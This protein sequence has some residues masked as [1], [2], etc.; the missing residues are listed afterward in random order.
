MK[1]R[2]EGR[3]EGKRQRQTSM[4]TQTLRNRQKEDRESERAK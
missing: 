1:K 3:K 4:Q 2:K